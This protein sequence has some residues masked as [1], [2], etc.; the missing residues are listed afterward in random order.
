MRRMFFVA[1]KLFAYFS[2]PSHW[3]GILVVATALCLLLR[4]RVAAG[5]CAG[6]AFAVLVLAGTPLLNG[7]LIRALEDRYPHPAWPAHVDGVLVLGSG[8]D[9]DTLL[10]RGAPQTN[11][12]AYRLIAAMAI[13]HRYPAARVV[14]T[15]GSAVLIG[16]QNAETVT[17][18]YVFSELRLDPTRLLLESRA[19]NTYENIL[20]SKA[21]I[22]PKPGEIWLLDTAAIHMPR[23]MAV[24]RKLGW[25]M[26]PWPSDYITAPGGD[27]ADL[28]D[29]GGNLG[30]SDYAMHEWIGMLAYRLSGKA[31]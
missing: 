5:I 1:S 23:A 26:V 10:Q 9:A 3:L 6:L 21:L 12:G 24:A 4:R 11:E 30:L 8:E 27:G 17:A 29:V 20:F 28:L 13:A 15:G 31:Q 18:R 19:R 2:P 16:A 14:F 22:H 25:R 7:P